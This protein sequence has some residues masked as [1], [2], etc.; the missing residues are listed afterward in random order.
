[1]SQPTAP[2]QSRKKTLIS[3]LV[4]L[5][6]TGV[7]VF[8]FKDHWTEITSALQRLS[9][10]QVAVVL[11]LGISYPLLEGCVSWVIVR[12]RLPD[13]KLRQG[14]DNAW[15]GT[16]GNV[17]TLGAGA[18]PFQTWYLYRCGLPLGTGVGLMTL[19]YVFHKATVLLYATV[20]LLLQH[21]WLLANTTGVLRYLPAAYGVVALIIVALV[22]VCVSPV[23][24]SLARW[25]LRYLPKTEKWQQ[26]R[27]D[28]LKQL[29]VLGTE[30]R[31]LLE[32]KKRC[33]A[34]FALHALKL[35]PAVLHPLPVHPVHGAYSPPL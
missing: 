11:L 30:S 32:D 10:W 4:L 31:R 35:V 26:R 1:M 22:L 12:G 15:S 14:M 6:L 33:L 19:Q 25:L 18:V 3:L 16:F 13:F 24:Q 27:R 7:I 34:I 29:D 28:W 5:A 20:M 23:V 21:R 17:V 9:L 8:I 2:R